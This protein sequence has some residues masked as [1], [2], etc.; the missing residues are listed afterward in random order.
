MYD[1]AEPIA[2]PLHDNHTPELYNST[3]WGPT[4]DSMDCIT[5]TAQL[6]ELNIGDWI[7]FRV[8]GIFGDLCSFFLTFKQFRTLERTRLQ[9]DA[10]STGSLA[11][12]WCIRSQHRATSTRPSS[13]RVSRLLRL[14][15]SRFNLVVDLFGIC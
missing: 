10:R 11:R 14:I 5:R 9:R 4:C 3:L 7:T 6:P 1:H 15:S 12:R 8:C 13:H 2:T